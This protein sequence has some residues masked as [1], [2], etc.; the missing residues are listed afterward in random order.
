MIIDFK[1]GNVTYKDLPDNVSNFYPKEDLLQVEYGNY[2]LDLGWYKSIFHLMIIK[3]SDWDFPVYSKNFSDFTH[4]Q[5]ELIEAIDV[6]DFLIDLNEI[7]EAEMYLGKTTGDLQKE[8]HEN[9]W[10]ITFPLGFKQMNKDWFSNFIEEVIDNRKNQINQ[11]AIFYLWYDSMAN[12]IRFNIISAM[13]NSL[14]F[15]CNLEV[16][17]D[18]NL[19]YQ[20]L[21]NSSPLIHVESIDD[22]EEF[23]EED[24]VLKVFVRNL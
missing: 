8:I 18:S 22:S 13:H 16:V 23:S 1:R 9:M 21:V 7:I 5:K 20:E 11:N 6:A 17:N 12:Q 2:T 19:I 15:G 10:M 14:P 24:Y 3:D 4:I